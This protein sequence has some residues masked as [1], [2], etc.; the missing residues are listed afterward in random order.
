MLWIPHVELMSHFPEII[1][2]PYPAEIG[3]FDGVTSLYRVS[4]KVKHISSRSFLNCYH[5]YSCIISQSYV[6]L[7]LMSQN[8]N[9]THALRIPFVSCSDIDGSWPD[10][11]AAGLFRKYHVAT[12]VTFQQSACVSMDATLLFNVQQIRLLF[13]FLKGGIPYFS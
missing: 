4:V 12:L 3:G 6:T 9:T 13:R 10:S 1:C 7:R 5:I 11:Q 8:E 2:Q